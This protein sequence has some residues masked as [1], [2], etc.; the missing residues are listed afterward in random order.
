M[1]KD[2]QF[3]LIDDTDTD[4]EAPKPR[5]E[6]QRGSVTVEPFAFEV[7]EF[8]RDSCGPDD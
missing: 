3:N 5:E 7:A 1:D 8:W 2:N 4:L 6:E